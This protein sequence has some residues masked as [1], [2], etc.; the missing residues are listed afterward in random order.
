MSTLLPVTPVILSF[1]LI[2]QVR[3]MIPQQWRM[4]FGI[5]FW[6]LWMRI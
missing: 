3:W 6:I 5:I 4:N 1:D 2:T